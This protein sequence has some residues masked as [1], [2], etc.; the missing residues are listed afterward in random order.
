MLDTKIASALNKIIQSS[1]FK[2]VSLEEQEV[3]K[4]DQFLRGRFHDL[5]LLS[6]DWRSWYIIGLRWFILCHCPW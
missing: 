1:P 5:R 4:E 2:K 6:S 3:E